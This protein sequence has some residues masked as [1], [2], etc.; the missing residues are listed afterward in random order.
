[1]GPLAHQRDDKTRVTPTSV[2][3]ACQ[4]LTT[5]GEAENLTEA[6]PAGI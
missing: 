6:V 2:F 1:M 3:G 4:T 5:L